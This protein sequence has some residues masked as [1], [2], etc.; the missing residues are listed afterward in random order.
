MAED[1]LSRISATEREIVVISP[2][3][4]PE[5]YG[6]RLY[7]ELANRGVSVKIVTNSLRS[8]NHVYVHPGYQRHRKSLLAAG[9]ELYELRADALQ[10]L[11][12]VPKDSAK[13]ITTH[14]KIG[15]H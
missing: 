15:Y 9:V 13:K 11:G 12:Q 7:S 3:F 1:V 14:K 5:D 2:Y 10:V 6:Q 8:T 4:V